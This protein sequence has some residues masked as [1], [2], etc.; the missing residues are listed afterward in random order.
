[1]TFKRVSFADRL[2]MKA[3]DVVR[4]FTGKKKSM[5][6]GVLYY[7]DLPES[8][9]KID[10]GCEFRAVLKSSVNGQWYT[11]SKTEEIESFNQL[12]RADDDLAFELD[13]IEWRKRQMNQV[14]VV[15]GE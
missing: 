9:R 7:S 1:M 3:N 12:F 13:G 10:L 14:N 11:V 5:V 2:A 8:L 4:F 6:A 15:E